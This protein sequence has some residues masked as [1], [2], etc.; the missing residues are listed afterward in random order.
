MKLFT[1]AIISAGTLLGQ[2]GHWDG[3]ITLPDREVPIVVDLDQQAGKWVGSM[4]TGP[5]SGLP[6]GD[7]KVAGSD[8]SFTISGAPGSPNFTG[9]LA[10]D[11]QSMT[12]QATMG[13]NSV[14]FTAKRSGDAKV[15]LP[16]PSSAIS[17]ELEGTWNGELNANGQTLHLVLNISSGAAGLGSAT[18]T[19]V[20]QG[21]ANL[22]VTTITQKDAHLHFEIKQIAGNY[23][24]DLN[25]AKTELNGTWTQ[26]P[27]PMPL[28]FV[29]K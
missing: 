7:I 16:P 4:S 26:G 8:V 18:V 3:K 28:K 9:K 17:K 12:G 29:K 1:I 25:A 10:A 6:L 11:G 22:P 23:E 20:D 15:E 14:P 24:G 27:A 21:N 13:G 19:S 5:M 2:A